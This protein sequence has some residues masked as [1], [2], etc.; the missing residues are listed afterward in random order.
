MSR[1]KTVIQRFVRLY[2]EIIHELKLVNHLLV[3]AEKHG[4]TITDQICIFLGFC[5]GLR[6]PTCIEV[7][8]TVQT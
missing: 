2:Q 3:Q 1:Y 7:A 6:I 5:S 4:L 8:W